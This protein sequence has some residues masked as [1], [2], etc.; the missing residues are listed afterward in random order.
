MDAEDDLIIKHHFMARAIAFEII[1]SF[2]RK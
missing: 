1:E 2:E